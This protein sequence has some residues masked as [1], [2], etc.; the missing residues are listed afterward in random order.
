MKSAP[1]T[2]TTDALLGMLSI[3]PMSGYE[4][5]ERIRESIGNFWSESFGQIYPAL[6]KLHKQ[7]LV[8]VEETGKA[9][10]KV[11]SLTPAGR[12]RLR[13]WLAIPPQPRRLRNEMLL[14]VFFGANNNLDDV[15]SQVLETRRRFVADLERY[16]AFEPVLRAR[17]AASSA[18]PFYLITLNHGIV[19]ARAIIDW[20]DQSLAT[21]DQLAADRAEA[22]AAPKQE[23]QSKE[24]Q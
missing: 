14:K 15:R 21:L 22:P 4:I 20:A 1:K 13:Q 6:A 16:T 12:E 2:T 9:G 17:R 8:D 19:E 23:E 24:P 11:Y 18:L 10:R 3:A 5:R 7:G